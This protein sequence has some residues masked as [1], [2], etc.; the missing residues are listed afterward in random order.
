[1]ER[2]GYSLESAG[3]DGLKFLH[4][5]GNGFIAGRVVDTASDQIVNDCL[6]CGV[7]RRSNS[8]DLVDDIGVTPSFMGHAVDGVDVAFNARESGFYQ[9]AILL[10]HIP[11]GGM[12]YVAG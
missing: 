8:G 9:M 4:G 5:R 12:G 11:S 7:Q 2:G 3:D 10:G 6:N 1:M